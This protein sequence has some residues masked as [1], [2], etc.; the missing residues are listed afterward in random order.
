MN[1]PNPSLSASFTLTYYTINLPF[2]TAGGTTCYITHSVMSRI[3][4]YVI[5]FLLLPSHSSLPFS[6]TILIPPPS[7][8]Y[9]SPTAK[10]SIVVPP[11]GQPVLLPFWMLFV[12]ILLEALRFCGAKCGSG[13]GKGFLIVLCP[14]FRSQYDL[15]VRA[16]KFGYNGLWCELVF[17]ITNW[18]DY[19][20][21]S[22]QGY[23][24]RI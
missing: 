19:R 24:L 13:V 2:R 14:P 18:S 22:L 23:E 20:Y 3:P 21:L 7:S 4:C 1:W 15:V 16:Y 6:P 17:Y 10:L 9:I 12:S 11:F 5:F 8:S